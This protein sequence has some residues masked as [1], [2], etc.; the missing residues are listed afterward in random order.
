[1]REI[2]VHIYFCNDIIRLCRIAQEHQGSV[3]LDITIPGAIYVPGVRGARFSSEDRHVCEYDN[4]ELPAK[5]FDAI[6]IN[7]FSLNIIGGVL[8]ICGIKP[9]D[10]DFWKAATKYI[11][12]H[13]EDFFKYPPCIDPLNVDRIRAFDISLNAYRGSVMAENSGDLMPLFLK[14]L[15]KLRYILATSDSIVNQMAVERIQ[16][17]GREWKSLV[18]INEKEFIRRGTFEGAGFRSSD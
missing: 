6:L 7:R 11:P 1:M 14:A 12:S 18:S 16:E 13:F 4:D 10:P 3:C 17:M 5:D 2:L 15:E 9:E 8:A